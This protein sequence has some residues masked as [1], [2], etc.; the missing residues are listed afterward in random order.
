MFV[1]KKIFGLILTGILFSSIA[2]SQTKVIAH[3]GYWDYPGSAQ[4]SIVAL[5]KAHEVKA[6]GSEFDV[7]I[8]ADGIPVVNHDND[9]QGFT[10]EKTNYERLR[11]LKLKNGEILP[12]LEQYLVNGKANKETKLILEVK[13]HSTKEIEDRAVAIIVEMVKSMQL[14]NQVEYISFS[15]N[16]CKEL[17]R[18]TPG[19]QVAYLN[20]D[21]SPAEI[22]NIGLTGIDYH[23]NVFEKKPEWIN[24][25]KKHGIT[26]NVWTV[27]KEDIMKKL[28][29]QGV[30]YI[31]TD[32]PEL[33]IKV[34]NSK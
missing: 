4:N 5:Y 25:A 24:E 11:N 12:T 8:T 1:K 9:I 10:I 2:Y 19:S 33:L 14:E 26:I 20:G 6:Y 27:N 23:Y 18:L 31:T 7:T 15:M 17:I 34:L 28:I 32:K 29:S 30:D 16:I 22:K 21:V 13:P 3:R